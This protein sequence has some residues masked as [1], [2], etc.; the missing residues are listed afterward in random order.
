MILLDAGTLS[1][2]TWSGISLLLEQVLNPWLSNSHASSLRK[3]L[4]FFELWK[5]ILQD[6]WHFGTDESVLEGRKP[7]PHECVW[8]E[9]KKLDILSSQNTR[10]PASAILHFKKTLLVQSSNFKTEFEGT[11][12]SAKY[13]RIT[14]ISR[15]GIILFSIC[16]I[17]T[18]KFS[19]HVLGYIIGLIKTAVLL[20]TVSEVIGR[21]TQMTLLLWLP[22]ILCLTISKLGM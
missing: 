14:N 21:A 22:M 16:N 7:W 19:T 15:Q 3:L 12:N 1:F 11:K 8:I 17:L 18:M 9:C 5:H 20:L 6:N 4:Q 2:H 10:K 13:F